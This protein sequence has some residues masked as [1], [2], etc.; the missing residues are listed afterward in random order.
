MA[1]IV[2][3][4][5]PLLIRSPNPR[6]LHGP[7]LVGD[8]DWP[9]SSWGYGL[10]PFQPGIWTDPCP[11][12]DIHVILHSEAAPSPSPRKCKSVPPLYGYDHVE[13]QSAMLATDSQR[14][15]LW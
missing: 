2:H 6:F 7:F 13:E 8:M 11:V 14:W 3:L 1:C 9:F 12:G 10:A 15:E 4:F 5:G